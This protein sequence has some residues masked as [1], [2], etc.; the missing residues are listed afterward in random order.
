[1]RLAIS[2]VNFREGVSGDTD[3]DGYDDHAWQP[4]VEKHSYQRADEHER[5]RDESVLVPDHG[6]V[7]EC[8]LHLVD[9]ISEGRAENTGED[10][11]CCVFWKHVEAKDHDDD[12]GTTTTQTSQTGKTRYQTHQ[13]TS[14]CRLKP[15][16][17]LSCLNAF[18]KSIPYVVGQ[19]AG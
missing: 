7:V 3:D 9:H 11:D 16:D 14:N 15:S 8:G 5:K 2:L 19:L 6:L 17:C 10:C 1:M 18:S 13:Q 4:F 12:V